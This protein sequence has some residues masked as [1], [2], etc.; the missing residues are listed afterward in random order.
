MTLGAFIDI[1]VPLSWL[2]DSLEKLPL[3]EHRNIPIEE[4]QKEGALMLFGEKYGDTVRTIKFGTSMEL[5]GGTHVKNTGDI[6]YFK[7]LSESA[8]AS[9]VRRIEAITQNGG[10]LDAAKAIIREIYANVYGLSGDELELK[11]VEFME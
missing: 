3:K 2:K 9:G 5:C 4:A 7:I 1:G 6:W 11:I 8:I 10:D